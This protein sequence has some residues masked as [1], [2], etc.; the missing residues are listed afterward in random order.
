M[1]FREP[2]STI[3]LRFKQGDELHGLE[4]TLRGMSIGEYMQATGM[5]GG[6]GEDTA[7]TMGRFFAA[8]V[9]W[10]LEDEAGNPI[11]VSEAPTRDQRLIRRLN[12]AYVDALMGVHEADPLAES[13]TSG[14]SSP[15]PAI[16]MAPLSESQAS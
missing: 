3:T 14:E 8:L 6:E 16:P 9:S 4:A 10:N 12:N 1:G 13:S 11:P 15:A 2:N 5:D 7:Q